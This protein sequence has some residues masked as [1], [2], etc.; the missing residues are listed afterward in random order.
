MKVLFTQPYCW[1]VIDVTSP[2]CLEAIV[3]LQ[4]LWLLQSFCLFIYNVFAALGYRR[5]F[6]I[7]LIEVGTST[8]MWLISW[9][10]PWN[11]WKGEH[12]LDT[13]KY[14]CVRS[15]HSWLWIWPVISNLWLLDFPV[16][17]IYNLESWART[18]PKLLL[19]GC[20]ITPTDTKLRHWLA[21]TLGKL[22]GDNF[23]LCSTWGLHPLI[24]HCWSFTPILAKIHPKS[25]LYTLQPCSIHYANNKC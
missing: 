2:S 5:I 24:F 20:F 23:L 3:W 12:Q 18:N 21:Q 10:G 7:G 22:M 25:Q 14:A 4:A 15:L 16:V 6:W 17:M 13:G 19:S 8:W 11:E 9:V 1:D